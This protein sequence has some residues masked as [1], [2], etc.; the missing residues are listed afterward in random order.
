MK[1][2]TNVLWEEKKT[3]VKTLFSQLFTLC[4]YKDSDILYIEFTIRWKNNT[5]KWR[6]K[7]AREKKIT[8]ILFFTFFFILF[9]IKMNMIYW[10][11]NLKYI[12]KKRMVS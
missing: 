11:N 3:N 6:M 1:P 4:I 5:L 9:G 10:E 2:N 7:T 12:K 8:N